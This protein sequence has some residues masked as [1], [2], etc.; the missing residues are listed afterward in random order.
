MIRG[1]MP[2]IVKSLNISDFQLKEIGKQQWQ[3]ILDKI[4]NTFIKN[5]NINNSTKHPY[6]ERL[7]GDSISICFENN[8]AYKVLDTLIDK[9]E[10]VWFLIQEGEK[11]WLYDGRIEYIEKVIE[12]C[13]AFEYYLVSKKFLWLLCENHHGYLIGIGNPVVD[14][15]RKLQH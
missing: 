3:Q 1:K 13:Y 4:E 12:E 5:Y 14:K 10:S 15:M 11:I 7:K 8:D 6:W 2:E 9:N